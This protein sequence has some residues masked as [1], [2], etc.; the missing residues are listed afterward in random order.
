[1]VLKPTFRNNNQSATFAL[2]NQ[3]RMVIN[4]TLQGPLLL[5][6]PLIGQIYIMSGTGWLG[7]LDRVGKGGTE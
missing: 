5:I 2:L 4:F 7:L 1:M 3:I 6:G